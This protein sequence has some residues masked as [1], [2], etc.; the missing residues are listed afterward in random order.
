MNHNW[1]LLARGGMELSW[2]Y[3]WA[4]FMALLWAQLTFPLPAAIGAMAFGAVTTRLSMAGNFRN[5]QKILFQ[6]VCFILIFLLILYRTQSSGIPFWH[7][8]WIGHLLPGAKDLLQWLILLFLVFFQGLFWQGGRLL[9]KES[10]HYQPICMQ[11]DKGLGLFM[12]L[13]IVYA[14]VDVR[15][16]LNLQNQD[17]RLTILAFFIFSLISI[18]LSRHQTHAQKSFILG[19]HGIGVLLSILTMTA[20]FASGIMLLAY[21]YLF[22]KADA[23]LVILKSNAAPFKP[24]VIKILIF[25]F[26]PRHLRQQPDIQN[27]KMLSGQEVGVPVGEGWQAFLFKILGLALIVL[28]GLAILVALAFLVYQLVLWLNKREDRPAEPISLINA[29]KRFLKA[30]R[31]FMQK[32][33][34]KIMV[35]VT[36]PDSAAMLY[37]LLLRWGR[38]SGLT[39]IPSDTPSEYGRRLMQSFPGLRSEINLIVAAFNRE[40]YGRTAIDKQTL[41]RIASAYRCMRRP[42]HWPSRLKNW[43]YQSH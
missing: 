29:F 34:R 16:E 26:R 1:L 37:Q 6:S 23:L 11:F 24:L 25:L 7:F 43:F 19:Y 39:P 12:A 36:G 5:Y 33:R 18:V 9:I 27:K 4:L 3:S 38:Y 42:R 10:R 21:P 22:H 15:T 20:I 17:I 8:D 30:C 41:V 2:R 40:L 32:T 31:V 35:M 13:L 14:L 28:L